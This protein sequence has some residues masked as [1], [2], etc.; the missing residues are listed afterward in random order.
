M[1]SAHPLRPLDSADV[2][3]LRE[4]EARTLSHF[5]PRFAAYLPRFA[6]G[7]MMLRQFS[8]LLN[9]VVEQ[10]RSHFRAVHESHNEI[11]V[12]DAILSDPSTLDARLLYE[13]KLPN[14]DT[15]IDFVLKEAD[16]RLTLIDVKTIKPQR[17]DRWEQYQRAISEGWLP[18]NVQYLLDQ[19][20]LGGELWHQAFASR[21]RFLEYSLELEAKLAASRYGDIARRRILMFCGEGFNWHQNE[22]E[23]FVTYYRTGAHCPSDPFS[24]AETR[25]FQDNGY[26][27][28]RSISSFGCL[29]RS[30]GRVEALRINWHVQPR[31]SPFGLR[32]VA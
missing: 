22:L 16:A 18:S 19:E 5:G 3:W 7:R 12:A 30:E 15:T 24:Q 29:N 23:D 17:L 11:C 27:F 28:V 14:T 4:Y 32:N 1:P 31:P 20:G 10:G 6:E 2:A 21:A 26:A 9:A 13:P 25:H 8:A